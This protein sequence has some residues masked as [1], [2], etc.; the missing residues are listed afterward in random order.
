[1]LKLLARDAAEDRTDR[2]A[3]SGVLIRQLLLS[4]YPCPTLFSF[5]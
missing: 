5:P 3:T 4:R 1:M 2:W